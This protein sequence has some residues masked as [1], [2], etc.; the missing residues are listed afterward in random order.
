MVDLLLKLDV[1]DFKDISNRRPHILSVLDTI[2]SAARDGI[3]MVRIHVYNRD[4]DK[5]NK[6]IK[7]LN[8]KGFRTNTD[9]I[10]PEGSIQILEIDW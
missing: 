10:E 6:I 8:Q 2:Y 4:L 5:W 3:C 1:Q 7:Q 9:K